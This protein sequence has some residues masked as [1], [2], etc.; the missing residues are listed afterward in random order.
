MYIMSGIQYLI[1]NGNDDFFVG[2]GIWKVKATIFTCYTLTKLKHNT[3]S[4][5]MEQVKRQE[6]PDPMY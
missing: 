6:T 3:I 4:Y 1:Q 2:T 5:D